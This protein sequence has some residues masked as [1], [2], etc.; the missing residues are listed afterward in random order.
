[1]PFKDNKRILLGDGIIECEPSIDEV[2]DP[3]KQTKVIPIEYPEKL[4]QVPGLFL[5][6]IQEVI[7]LLNK[8]SRS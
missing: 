5:K 7:C 8:W 3:S 6:R 2:T 4:L 1:M